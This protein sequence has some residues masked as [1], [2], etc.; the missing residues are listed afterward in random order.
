MAKYLSKK[1]VKKH[2]ICLTGEG[3]EL[4]VRQT[5]KALACL[6]FK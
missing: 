2:H 1:S 6:T 3:E 5:S 4:S